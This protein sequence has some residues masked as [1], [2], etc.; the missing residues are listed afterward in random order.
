MGVQRPQKVLVVDDEPD[1]CYLFNRILR[2]KNL[3]TGYAHNLAEAGTSV[4][5]DPPA[6]IFLDNCLPDGLGMDFI[7]YLK[8]NFPQTRVIMVT[9]NDGPADRKM[10]F[11]RGADDCW[12]KPLS[13]DLINQ[14]L[15]SLSSGFL[16]ETFPAV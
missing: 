11:Q 5:E 7:P 6:L 8:K 14:V 2:G 10:A 1:I 13:L 15:D 4:R 16:S 3:K 12:G 9:A